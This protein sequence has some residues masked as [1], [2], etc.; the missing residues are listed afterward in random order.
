MKIIKFLIGI[1][2]TVT[3]FT[4]AAEVIEF[5]G[6]TFEFD[7][8]KCVVT[9]PPSGIYSGDVV[10]P[11]CVTIDDKEIPVT[12]IGDYAFANSTQ[13]K[14]VAIPKSV[15][16]VGRNAFQGCSLITEI[17]FPEGVSEI[18]DQT[19]YE[20]LSLVSFKGEGVVSVGKSAFYYCS[21][22]SS[23]I[24]SEGLAFVG[25]SGFNY[26]IS[27]ENFEFP[28][29]AELGN[30]VFYGCSSLQK[31]I[32][33]FNLDRIPSSTFYGCVALREVEGTENIMEIG[34]NAFYT[35][36]SLSTFESGKALNKIGKNAFCFCSDLDISVINGNGEAIIEEHAF[37]GCKSLQKIDFKGIRT[38]G[39][40]AFSNNS[41]L[42]S[43]FFDEALHDIGDRA[44]TRCDNI[45]FITSKREIPPFMK[46]TAFDDATYKKAVLVVPDGSG[47]LYRQTP[48]WSYFDH[49]G[50]TGIK[51]VKDE[52]GIDVLVS[53]RHIEICDEAQGIVSL[54]SISGSKISETIKADNKIYIT[55][56]CNGSYIITLNGRS[57]K[58]II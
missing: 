20:C 12:G 3:S 34:D 48:P 1:I 41:E 18:K 38:I 17:N 19:F 8:E 49:T 55:A 50:E 27:I 29:E 39:S 4:A 10:I 37:D 47:E 36:R 45:A 16:D 40:D 43:L 11:S 14:T 52:G 51:A 9:N 31:V 42:Q 56:P 33:P 23:V 28:S 30:N 22:L 32:L 24:F 57:K 13:L 6:I 44:F 46:N 5:G 15:T 25:D 54:F 58:I 21:S 2:A 35:C 26:C 53:G 7:G